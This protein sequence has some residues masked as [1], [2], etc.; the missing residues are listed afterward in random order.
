MPFFSS[1]N[2]KI[3][4]G[5]SDY[6]RIKGTQTTILSD[7]FETTVDFLHLIGDIVFY[8]LSTPTRFFLPVVKK[9]KN[10]RILRAVSGLES[11]DN[12]EDFL[13]FFSFFKKR[14]ENDNV[15]RALKVVNTAKEGASP[16]S[17]LLVMY[18]SSVSTVQSTL[19]S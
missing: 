11:S 13:I 7:R 1:Q 5:W 2:T 18:Y 6:S 9:Y 15:K 3:L 16:S 14:E 10:S 17:Y 19:D 8:N 4:L 12:F